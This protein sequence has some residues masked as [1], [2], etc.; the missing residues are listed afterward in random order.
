[1]VIPLILIEQGSA[2]SVVIDG[3]V[4]ASQQSLIFH[5]PVCLAHFHCPERSMP[6]IIYKGDLQPDCL[7]DR[8]VTGPR[9]PTS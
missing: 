9:Q 7:A 4:A 5:C 6:Y 2:W 1:M 8:P 3:T